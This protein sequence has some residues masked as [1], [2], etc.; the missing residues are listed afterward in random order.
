MKLTCL[1]G[2]MMHTVFNFYG[3][4]C[5]PTRWINTRNVRLKDLKEFPFVLQA[6]IHPG[7]DREAL[8]K[9]GYASVDDYF[10][11]QSM[12]NC[13]VVGWRGKQWQK[14]FKWCWE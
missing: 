2:L 12:F 5:N 6:I 10:M 7:F 4:F 13:S 3:Y 11:G 8:E 14:E 1:A 9:E